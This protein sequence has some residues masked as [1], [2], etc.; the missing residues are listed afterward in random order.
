MTK[1]RR[2]PA[3]HF[4]HIRWTRNDAGLGLVNSRTAEVLSV[5]NGRVTFQLEAARSWNWAATTPQ[6][7]HLDRMAYQRDWKHG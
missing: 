7:R 3:A 2:S 6:L 4:P 5:G 1:G